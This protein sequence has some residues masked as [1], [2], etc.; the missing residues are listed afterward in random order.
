M[1]RI[2]VKNVDE[3]LDFG[4]AFG[5]TLSLGTV[6]TLEGD[7]AAGKTTLTKGIALGLGITDVIDSPTFSI[8]KEYDG[9]RFP[10]YHMDVYRLDGDSDV[11]FI[12]EYFD[13]DGICV[14]EWASI[15][16]Q[17]LPTSRID[18]RISRLD[19]D[20]REIEVIKHG[21]LA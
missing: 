10:L 9:G 13:R 7:L 3:T 2:I 14:V 6:V 15:I 1:E 8:V 20:T 5:M 16:A 12:L 11:E 4:K 17:D 19:G 21:D 18:I